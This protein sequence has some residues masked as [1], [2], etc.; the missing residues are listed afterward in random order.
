VT[1]TLDDHTGIVCAFRFSPAG[2]A[3]SLKWHEIDSAL[4][5]D[6]P[7]TWLH[8]N[9][10]DQRVRHWIE[11]CAA[12]PRIARESLL[13]GDH[14]MRIDPIGDGLMGILGDVQHDL[15][16][17]LSTIGLLRFY[18]D[19]HHLITLRH[20]P[21]AA[22]DNLRREIATGTMTPA[23][24]ID[25]LI[26]LLN[27]LS[28]TLGIVL[29]DLT[30]RID[31]IEDKLLS[32]KLL[33]EAGELALIRRD[34]A[35]LRRHLVP[36]RQ[37]LAG[38]STMMPSSFGVECTGRIN[39]ALERLGAAGSDLEQLQER[40]V[41]LQTELSGRLAELTNRNL[42][43]LSIITAVFLPL[44]LISGIFGMN[45]GGLPWVGDNW[46]FLWVMVVSVITLIATV[47][48]LRW[49]RML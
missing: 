31:E 2:P 49:R 36:Q 22:V 48:L 16:G 27:E 40:A 3:Q 4:D 45:V 46:G 18:L 23:G 24:P 43:V 13:S 20:E 39:H 44:T 1:I 11:K 28:R 33:A 6:L 26:Q 25:V 29:A 9:G 7:G 14:R 19:D 34:L 35:Q 5:R 10:N 15:D 47:I 12:I 42:Y 8:L 38:L 17:T 32:H 41:M 30:E 37:A 21:L